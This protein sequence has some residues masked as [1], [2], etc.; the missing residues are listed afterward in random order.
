MSR[1]LPP[2]GATAW[3]FPRSAAGVRHLVA[4]AGRAGLPVEPLLVGSGLRAEDLDRVQVVTAAQELRVVRALARLL[5]DSGA[6]VGR[7]YTAASFGVMGWAMRASATLGEAVGIALSFID[8]SFAFVI[9]QARLEGGPGQERVVAELD[10]TA[11]PRDVR[12]WL[13]ERDAT[14]V[15]TVLES[16][17]PGGVGLV[18]VVEGDRA[19][20]S[21]AA[22][23]LDRPLVRERGADHAAAEAACQALALPRRERTGTVADVRVLVA[24]RLREGAPMAEVAAALGVTERTLRRRLAAEGTG[25]RALVEE[26][27]SGLAAELLAVGL[28]V[29]DVA[30][31]LGYAETAPLTRAHRR[32]T[33]RPPSGARASSGTGS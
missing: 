24:Q 29:A 17:V 28:P 15:A 2:P 26:V 3:D 13:L 22:T 27:R 10:A 32:W 14:A 21:F 7:R 23:E 33:G 9:P 8:L 1:S 25:Y 18:Q 20:L 4:Y 12:R 31:R 16:L 11:L 19:T 5:P 30:A 6:D